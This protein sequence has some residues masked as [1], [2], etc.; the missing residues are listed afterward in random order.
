MKSVSEDKRSLLEN[1]EETSQEPRSY[2]VIRPPTPGSG[3]L[4]NINTSA[5]VCNG[6]V[7]FKRT[8]VCNN[9]IYDKSASWYMLC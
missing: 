7:T 2:Q 4:T 1:E 9:T 8:R 6:S 3:L 5:H